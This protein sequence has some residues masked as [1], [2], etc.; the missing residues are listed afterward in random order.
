MASANPYLAPGMIARP[1][2][3]A[4]PGGANPYAAPGMGT[5]AGAPGESSSWPHPTVASEAIHD[6]LGDFGTPLS[7]MR[8]ETAPLVPHAWMGVW[9]SILDFID[10]ERSKR[11]LPTTEK[12]AIAMME[13]QLGHS[14]K[15][16]AVS[17]GGAAMEGGIPLEGD[18]APAGKIVERAARLRDFEKAGVPPRIPTVGQARQSGMI[19]KLGRNLPASPIA[20]GMRQDL[21]ATHAAAERLAA[22]HGGAAVPPDQ[23]A[24][25]AQTAVKGFLKNN[26]QAKANYAEV[27]RLMHGAPNSTVPAARGVADQIRQR[28]ASIPE[29]RDFFT[30]PIVKK[31]LGAIEPQTEHIPEKI[32]SIL[33]GE[34]RGR[35]GNLIEAGKPIVTRPA[36]DVTH[37]P[38][39]HWK[40][41]KE[42]RTE[43]DYT[44]RN[45]GQS[46]NREARRQLYQLRGA[47]T[48]D[49][50]AVAR[51]KG[52]AAVAA[53]QKANADYAE[54]M[55][56]YNELAPLVASDNPDRTF[57]GINLAAEKNPRTQTTRDLPLLQ[58]ARKAMAPDEWHSLGAAL[59]RRLGTPTPGAPREPGAPDFSITAF[60][61]NW[62]RLS[63][64]AKDELFGTPKP[65]STRDA[66]ETLGR[67]AN[68]QRNVLHLAA[69][70]PTSEGTAILA[71]MGFVVDGLM[72]GAHSPEFVGAGATMGASYGIAKLLMWP[73]FAKWMY[74]LPKM[75]NSGTTPQRAA[76][77]LLRDALGSAEITPQPEQPK[78]SPQKASVSKIGDRGPAG[79]TV[80][81]IGAGAL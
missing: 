19:A 67:V 26:K 58:A 20:R 11:P 27:D 2:A 71:A 62:N 49:M 9:N 75:L 37:L 32:S 72:R 28:F 57:S 18:F 39:V 14:L 7:L 36:H 31:V 25:S 16:Y 41:I 17:L 60:A 46:A 30:K 48:Q 44:L 40:D 43:I 21:D 24:L 38:D 3:R 56:I 79:G 12:Q 6:P 70:S 73:R 54:R 53:L 42:L 29:L 47:L 63:E 10:P 52:P 76:Q 15:N 69:Q 1:A 34:F 81:S 80:T 65:D 66:L 33:P 64:S 61:T 74:R 8:H 51:S 22:A 78:R 35:S 59:I 13:D 4:A 5:N 45:L 55:R 23:A 77:M 68:A 50:Y